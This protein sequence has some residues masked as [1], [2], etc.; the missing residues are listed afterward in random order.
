MASAGTKQLK[1]IDTLE[2]FKQAI[3]KYKPKNCPCR[4]L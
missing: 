2:V 1:K 4:A 3:K